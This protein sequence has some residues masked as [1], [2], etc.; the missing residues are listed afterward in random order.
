[1]SNGIAVKSIIA[2]IVTTAVPLGFLCLGRERTESSFA[3]DRELATVLQVLAK[4]KAE[5]SE[6]Y[7]LDRKSLSRCFDIEITDWED[8]STASLIP[9]DLFRSPKPGNVLDSIVEGKRQIFRSTKFPNVYASFV[10]HSN[11]SY[12]ESIVF[13][14]YPVEGTHITVRFG[15]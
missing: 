14:N 5:T 6:Y 15:P 9:V 10:N 8:V 4:E 13:R 11:S 12:C 3:Q 7:F 2:I 1:M